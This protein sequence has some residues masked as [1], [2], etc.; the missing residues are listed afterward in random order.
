MARRKRNKAVSRLRAQL[1]WMIAGAA[2]IAPRISLAQ[3][4][5][6]QD[7]AP[8]PSA[9]GAPS[10]GVTVVQVPQEPSGPTVF[11]PGYPA[12]GTDLEGHLPSSARAVTD[13]SHSS[14]GFDLNQRSD[15]KSSVRGGANGAFIGEGQYTPELHTV[16]RGD[17]LWEIS[18]RYY[19]NPYSWPKL[20]AQNP[21]ILNPHWIYPGDRIRLREEEQRSTLASR[22]SGR[23]AAV[24]P[25]TIFLRETGWVDDLA[26]DTWGEVV[27]SPDDQMLLSEGDD[28][29]V[30]LSG[31][32]EVSVGQM[33]TLFK[34]LRAVSSQDGNKGELVSVRG[35]AR[36]ERVN[37]KSKMVKAKITESLDV[38]ERGISAGVATRH[39][40]VVSPVTSEV[41]LEAR[42]LASIDPLQI[43]GQHHLVF[44]DKGEKEG[45]KVG[46][47]FFAIRKGDRWEQT[48]KTTGK[49]TVQ[50][51]RVEDERPAQIEPMKTDVPTDK[52]PDETYAELRVV[53]VR[54]HTAAALVTASL[55]EMDKSARLISRKGF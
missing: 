43:F 34:P 50:R 18:N 26:K 7:A 25:K 24:P 31:D 36:I 9:E 53:R 10:Q 1:A 11:V 46:Q 13:T 42:I 2:W 3:Q 16:R 51:P 35:S 22:F 47:R 4:S 23:K 32:R 55:H 14:D 17:T 8:D 5:A 28:V 12:P 21:Q 48:L 45:V 15:R 20:W 49:L 38:I 33:L 29:Y 44:I 39:F 27:G 52:L 19:Q 40:D 6:P 30:Q 54:E 37:P 41:D